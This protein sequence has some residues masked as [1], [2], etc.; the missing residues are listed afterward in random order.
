VLL[1]GFVIYVWVS[2]KVMQRKS[3]AA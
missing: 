1:V 3:A 2:R